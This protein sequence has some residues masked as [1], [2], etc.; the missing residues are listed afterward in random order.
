LIL[1]SKYLG[2]LFS[3]NLAETACDSDGS[4]C[5][6]GDSGGPGEGC[7]HRKA[8]Q[9]D[10]YSKCAPPID[11][12][13][14]A[15]FAAPMSPNMDTVDMSLVDGYS[16][17]FKLAVK[18]NCTRQ[19]KP[20]QSMD[21]SGLSLNSCPASEALSSQNV[22]L[23]AQSPAGKLAGCFSPCM[24]LTDDKWSKPVGMA[25]S[26]MV[27]PYCC[28]CASGGPDICKSGPV[29]QTNYVQMVHQM[30]PEAYG[31]AF[32]DIRATIVCTQA[33]QYI[34]TYFCPS[35]PAGVQV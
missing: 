2:L 33:T 1:P 16:L 6:I 30:C 18:G 4:N 13:F 28:A 22:D 20:F 27:A 15:T 8:G 25:D 21:C 34:V 32:D 12:K 35:E 11:S 26:P 7:V 5:A 24:K 17:P 31:F 9:P 3:D 19:L 29:Q 10:D 14:E 23:R